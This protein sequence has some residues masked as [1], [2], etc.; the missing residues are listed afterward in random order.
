MSLIC[1]NAKHTYLSVVRSSISSVNDD[2][3]NYSDTCHNTELDS[4]TNMVV[5]CKHAVVV[6]H[7]GKI[8]EVKPFSPDCKSM[9]KVPIVD[10]VIK[11]Y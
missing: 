7:T 1:F 10:A 9:D 3:N 4:H 8:V 5:V 2:Y 6:A 11:W